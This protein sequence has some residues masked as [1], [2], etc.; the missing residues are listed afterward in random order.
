[1]ER[2]TASIQNIYRT[3]CRSLFFV[4]TVAEHRWRHSKPFWALRLQNRTSPSNPVNHR[5]QVH[6]H[7]VRFQFA[8]DGPYFRSYFLDGFSLDIIEPNQLGDDSLRVNPTQPMN[9]NVKL[10]RVIA[11]DGR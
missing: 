2:I 9:Q 3:I 4:S 7:I 1:M 8:V 6:K 5:C 10:P 11:D